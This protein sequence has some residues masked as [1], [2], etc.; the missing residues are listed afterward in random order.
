[1][2]YE[3]ESAVLLGKHG[4]VWFSLK[5]WQV[6]RREG[7]EVRRLPEEEGEDGRERRKEEEVV[8][9]GEGR[10]TRAVGGGGRRRRRW[11]WWWVRS[12]IAREGIRDAPSPS[13]MKSER[14]G[15]GARGG[16][17]DGERKEDIWSE[18]MEG[19]GK[20]R[21]SNEVTEDIEDSSTQQTSARMSKIEQGRCR[22]RDS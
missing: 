22:E 8:M 12:W 18:D 5:P 11:W 15:R 19:G 6:R 16:E 1:M 20:R 17:R 3:R 7:E 2:Q 9:C 14:K 13:V 10:G 4:G 21:E